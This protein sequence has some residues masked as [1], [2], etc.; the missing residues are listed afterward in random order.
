MCV[1]LEKSIEPVTSEVDMVRLRELYESALREHGSSSHG[2][3]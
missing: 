1:N 2:M 3:L